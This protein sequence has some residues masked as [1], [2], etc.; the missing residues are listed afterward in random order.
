MINELCT[1][2]KQSWP[3]SRYSPSIYFER[4]RKTWKSAFKKVGVPA[5]IWSE[6]LLNVNSACLQ[7]HY[8]CCIVQLVQQYYQNVLVYLSLHV[9]EYTLSECSRK[10][11]CC[12]CTSYTQ[13]YWSGKQK[14]ADSKV[15]F[16][17]FVIEGHICY[18]FDVRLVFVIQID[19][20]KMSFLLHSLTY[21]GNDIRGA[22]LYVNVTA[23]IK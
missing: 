8:S 12:I 19:I 20:V 11:A 17:W 5:E 9:R 13:T 18:C 2:R 4:L 6:P 14:R 16:L 1:G 7:I 21:N 10:A 22:P 23:K 3:I 15:S